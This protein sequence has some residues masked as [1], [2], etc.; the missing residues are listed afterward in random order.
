MSEEG[1]VFS[2]QPER[3]AYNADMYEAFDD[4]LRVPTWHTTHSMDKRRFFCALRTVVGIPTFNPD[5]FGEYMDRKRKEPDSAQANLIQD[6]YE[7][8]REHYV[9]AAWAVKGYLETTD[10]P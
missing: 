7:I 2:D 6:A 8:A 4:F 5:L 3:S 9:R 10:C 1:A